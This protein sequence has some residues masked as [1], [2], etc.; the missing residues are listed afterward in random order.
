MKDWVP[1]AIRFFKCVGNTIGLAAKP[2]KYDIYYKTSTPVT[3][4][5]N[6]KVYRLS[7]VSYKDKT[8]KA[9]IVAVGNDVYRF[10]YDLIYRGYLINGGN[11]VRLYTA[12]DDLLTAKSY[13]FN[14]L[15][16][17]S[18]MKRQAQE[19]DVAK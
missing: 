6:G 9:G 11:G 10:E 14:Y 5:M 3:L 17:Q 16:E 8:Y 12:T 2:S 13:L 7:D 15:L 18:D 4:T 19:E 1:K